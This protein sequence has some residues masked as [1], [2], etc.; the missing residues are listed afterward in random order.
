MTKNIQFPTKWWQWF[1]VYPTVLTAFFAAVPTV[2]EALQANNIGVNFGRS[3]EAI[4]QRNLW[5]KNMSC[6][7]APYDWLKTDTNTLVDATIC[8]TGDVLVRIKTPTTQAYEW[9]TIDKYD[10]QKSS[11][12]LLQ[13]TISVKSFNNANTKQSNI[14]T[15]IAQSITVLCQKWLNKSMV[16]RRVSIPND[17]CYDEIV[18]TYTG[19]VE[20]RTSAPCNSQC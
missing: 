15:K 8:K 2:V 17:G 18:N 5:K 19:R 7:Q 12:N 1:L 16:L 13:N 10:S 6:A 4:I 20:Q 11:L 14:G 9:V 3:K